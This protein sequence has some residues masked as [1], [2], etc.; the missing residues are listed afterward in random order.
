MSGS[1]NLCRRSAERGPGIGRFRRRR[2]PRFKQVL[3]DDLQLVAPQAPVPDGAIVEDVALGR[4]ED[5]SCRR[6]IAVLSDPRAPGVDR[7]A[8]RRGDAGRHLAGELAG[9]AGGGA[10]EGTAAGR[11]WRLPVPIR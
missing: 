11:C 10:E 3:A 8:Q 9:L 6:P 5:G 4:D 1:P 2:A 7:Q